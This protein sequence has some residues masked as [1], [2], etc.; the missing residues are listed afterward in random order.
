MAAVGADDLLIVA[1]QLRLARRALDRITGHHDVE[2]ML[3]HLFGQFC[4]GK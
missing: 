3:D 4:I 1:E 2:Q